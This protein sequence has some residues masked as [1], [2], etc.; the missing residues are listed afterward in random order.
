MIY[1]SDFGAAVDPYWSSVVLLLGADGANGSTTFYDESPSEHSLTGSGNAQITTTS[2]I[3]ASGSALFDGTGDLIYA[4]DSEDWNFGA[5]DFTVEGWCEFAVKQDTQG[6]V[7]QWDNGGSTGNNNWFFWITGG[8][9]NFRISNGFTS[10]DV[11]G[12]FVPTLGVKYFISASRNGSVLRLFAGPAG[13]DATL[14]VKATG[15]SHVLRAST[16]ALVIGA[17]GLTSSFS[18]YDFNG[19]QDELRITKGIGR[20]DDDA[21]FLAPVAPFYRAPLSFSAPPTIT[22]AS[23]FYAVGDELTAVSGTYSAPGYVTWQWNRDGAPIGGE[24]G[25]GYTL[26]AGDKTHTITV[27]QTVTIG[28]GSYSGTSA[29]IGPIDDPTFQTDTRIAGA[30]T[31]IAGADTRTIQT[32]I[33]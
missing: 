31:R 11:A 24:T 14:I 9:L 21:D 2:P 27:T 5:G 32:R 10:I 6:I 15:Y 4:P 13:G 1:F 8:Q 12:A 26:V 3:M 17:I 33:S 23:G 29:G 7:G 16:A 30:D 28:S 25:T 19:K 20:Y 22:S 18:A